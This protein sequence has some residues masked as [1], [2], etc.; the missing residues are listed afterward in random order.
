M[1]DLVLQNWI[2]HKSFF[3]MPALELSLVSRSMQYINI[4]VTDLAFLSSLFY[5]SMFVSVIN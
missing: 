4:W 3:F 1:H 5:K 2:I